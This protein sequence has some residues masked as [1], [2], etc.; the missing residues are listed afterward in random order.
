MRSVI[1][2]TI[3]DESTPPDRN[4]PSG[5]SAISRRSTARP[6]PSSSRSRHSGSLVARSTANVTSQNSSMRGATSPAAYRSV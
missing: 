3:S 6:S 1:S 5:T 2:A 4:A